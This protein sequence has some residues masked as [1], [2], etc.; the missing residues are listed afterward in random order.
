MTYARSDRSPN[1]PAPR[2]GSE[3]AQS[4]LF[5]A[6]SAPSHTR[7]SELIARRLKIPLLRTHVLSMKPYLAPL[8]YSAQAVWTLFALFKR[9]PQVVFV[10]NPP[11]F[12][13]LFAWIYCALCGASLIIDSHTD[14]LLCPPIWKWSLPLHRFLSRRAATTLVTNEYLR[15]L[16]ASWGAMSHIIADVPSDLPAGTPYPMEHPFNVAMISSYSPDE[17]LDRVFQ[18]AQQLP[19]VGVFVTGD[20]KRSQRPVRVDLP[21]NVHLTG[22]LPDDRYYGLLRSVQA[23]M[24]LT[25]VDHTMQR[26]ACESVWLGQP[27]IT[28]NWPVL[29]QNFYQ[30]TVH[31]DN[32]VEGIVAGIRRMRSEHDEL[33]KGILV[34]QQERRQQWENTVSELRSLLDDTPA[35]RP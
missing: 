12:A 18:A 34:L 21:P 1:L 11:I 15:Q 10:Q 23:A 19:D 8:R 9:R 25:T 3:L 33:A 2:S 13:P 24:A 29:R 5:L 6:W 20:P 28:S 31:V 32:T 35:G 14:A 26:G 16:V 22:L 27:I 17:P 7:R 30:G 4:A